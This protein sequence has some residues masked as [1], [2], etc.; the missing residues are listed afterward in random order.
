[1]VEDDLVSGLVDA[2][3]D[4]ILVVDEGGRLL[5]VNHQA[6]V[7]FGRPREELIGASV[8][9]LMPEAVRDAHRRHRETYW[10]HPR[11]RP[12]GIGMTL[13]A[14]RGDGTE[15]PVEVSLS[16]LPEDGSRRTVAVVRDVSDRVAADA[17]LRQ[18]AED[19]QVLEDRERI[20][21]DLHDLVIQRLFAAGMTLQATR[22]MTDD[23]DIAKRVDD[24]VDELDATIREIRTVIF[25]LQPNGERASGLRGDVAELVAAEGAVH[26]LE[27]RVHFDGVIDALPDRVADDVRATLREALANVARHARAAVVDV[28]LE[29]TDEVVL[30][31][32]DDG[33]GIPEVPEPG[34]GLSNMVRRAE[35]HGGTCVVT[36]SSDGGTCVEWRVPNG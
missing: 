17:R 30:T 19:L 28:T 2:A 23:P 5:L 6:E 24:A 4:A 9:T 12:M 33:I 31:V 15:V 21:R 11:T 10:E 26:G 18:A 36:P 14:L 29:A 1:V 34:Q 32:V 16:P 20:A 3:P 7:L 22:G 25:G 13:T 8:E 27:T 35:D